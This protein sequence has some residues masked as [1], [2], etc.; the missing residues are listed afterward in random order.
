MVA[1]RCHI[2][3]VVVGHYRSLMEVAVA[4]GQKVEVQMAE[5]DLMVVVVR[6]RYSKVVTG[7]QKVDSD[8]THTTKDHMEVQKVEEEAGESQLDQSSAVRSSVLGAVMDFLFGF[9]FGLEAE[10]VVVEVAKDSS[11]MSSRRSVV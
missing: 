2:H 6:Y 8:H 10:V 11:E 4:V 3:E 1:G 9:G 7:A 5:E